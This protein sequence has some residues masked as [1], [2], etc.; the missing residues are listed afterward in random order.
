MSPGRLVLAGG[1]GAFAGSKTWKVACDG[2]WPVACREQT[3]QGWRVFSEYLLCA[4]SSA[5]TC[6]GLRGPGGAEEAPAPP[7]QRNC[8][9]RFPRVPWLLGPALLRPVPG[10]MGTPSP[11]QGRPARLMGVSAVSKIFHSLSKATQCVCGEGR[12]RGRGPGAHGPLGA[13]PGP[14]Q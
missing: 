1:G 6:R 10:A 8:S 13:R 4:R 3:A 9:F 5:P 2:V 11:F 12:T 14:H 7:S